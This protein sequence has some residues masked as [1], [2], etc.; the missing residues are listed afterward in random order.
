MKS[1]L[2]IILISA[3][4]TAI[5]FGGFMMYHDSNGHAQCPIS[6]LDGNNCAN[7]INPFSQA[8]SHLASIINIST[9]IVV[10]PVVLFLILALGI[11]FNFSTGSPPQTSSSAYFEFNNGDRADIFK[12]KFLRWLS[13]LGKRDPWEF[14]AAKI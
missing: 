9:G 11:F 12:A 3:T 10:W 7:I 8:V 6:A 4:L 1:A 14:S 5:V 13:I 2:S